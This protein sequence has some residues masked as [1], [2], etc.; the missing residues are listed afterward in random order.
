MVNVLEE[1]PYPISGLMLACFSLG[2]YLGNF[3]SAFKYLFGLLG[4]VILVLLVSKLIVYPTSLGDSLRIVTVCSTLGTFSMSLMIFS[5]YFIDV[6]QGIAFCLWTLGLV[7]H[8][9]LIVYFTYRFIFNDFS[10]D[11]VYPSYW[12]VYIGISMA[13]ISGTFHTF[14]SYTFIFFVFAF[15]L[16]FPT[17]LLV[18]YRYIKC[19]VVSDV[20]KPLICI[21]T[22]IYSILIVAYVNSFNVVDRNFLIA[23]YIPAC[24][25]YVLSFVKLIEYRDLDFYPSFSAFSFPFVISVIASYNVYNILGYSL[26]AYIVVFESLVGVFCVC[27][28]IY[29]YLKY[30]YSF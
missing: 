26:L 6:N 2:L 20:N 4:L 30:N 12:I 19:P 16:M 23:L 22:A 27:Y 11:N 25:C 15:I 18:C 3:N 28:V 14:S 29:K 24:I 21:F 17:M 13:S 10:L 5:N 7:L 8:I 1:T 9:L